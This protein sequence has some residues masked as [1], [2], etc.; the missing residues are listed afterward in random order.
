MMVYCYWS[1]TVLYM[2]QDVLLARF[3]LLSSCCCCL[4]P[5]LLQSSAYLYHYLATLNP[6]V[7]S[8]IGRDAP[9]LSTSSLFAVT[10]MTMSPP[11]LNTS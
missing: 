1:C 5:T 3:I 8:D 6:P 2:I 4:Y 9:Q 10:S 11:V 7:E